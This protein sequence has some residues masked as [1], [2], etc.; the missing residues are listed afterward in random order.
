MLE[1][2]T[3][4]ELLAVLA[5]YRDMGVDAALAA[6]PIDW[7]ARGNQAPGAGFEARGRPAQSGP[8]PSHP[9]SPRKELKTAPPPLLDS[10]PPWSTEG[11]PARP[12]SRPAARDAAP[13]APPRMSPPSLP[14][15]AAPSSLAAGPPDAAVIAAREQAKSAPSLDKLGLLLQGFE[16]CGLK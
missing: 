13:I 1:D 3:D 15:R 12:V 8:P 7:L 11:E 10:G 9:S 4:A 5:W 6:T 2:L 16:G 14:V